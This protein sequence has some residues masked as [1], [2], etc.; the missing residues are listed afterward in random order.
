MGRRCR[1]T[2]EASSPRIT[3]DPPLRVCIVANIRI[4]RSGSDSPEPIDLYADV[5]GPRTHIEALEDLD[6]EDR[7]EMIG[8]AMETLIARV[9]APTDEEREMA[10]RNTRVMADF[11]A[12]FG[13]PALT[14]NYLER[15]MTRRRIKLVD[16]ARTHNQRGSNVPR[17]WRERWKKMLDEHIAAG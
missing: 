2:K 16:T 5:G 3:G 9:Q 4:L 15:T 7:D 14:K 1:Q 11:A 6:D 17:V 13:L 8:T 12:V 10:E